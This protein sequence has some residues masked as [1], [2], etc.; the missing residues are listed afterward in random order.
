VIY[1]FVELPIQGGYEQ[2]GVRP[3]VIIADI[4][5]DIAIVIPFTSNLKSLNYPNSL[6]IKPT[7]VNRLKQ[8]S[9]AMIFLD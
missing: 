1:F 2:H 5:K 4:S 3:T 7:K 8:D 6:L 9:V